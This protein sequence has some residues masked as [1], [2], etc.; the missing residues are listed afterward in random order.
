MNPIERLK[1]LEA[2][3]TPGTWGVLTIGPKGKPQECT[4]YMQRPDGGVLQVDIP[5]EDAAWMNAL[6]NLGRELLALWEAAQTAN[7]G[8]RL[9]GN[10]G[11]GDALNAVNAKALEMMGEGR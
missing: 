5:L 3:A 9:C 7:D 4:T 11:I 1:E 8:S 10:D 2:K 6:R